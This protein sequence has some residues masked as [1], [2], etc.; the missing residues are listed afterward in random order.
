M[1]DYALTRP[2]VDAKRIALM[3][4]SFG[5]Y[6]APR[7][8]AYEHRL[9]ACIADG[10]VYSFLDAIAP[11]GMTA[12]DVISLAQAKPDD[13]SADVW[14]AAEASVS[15]RW[16]VENGMF[17]FGAAS[18]A[19]WYLKVAQYTMEGQAGKIE[20]PTLIVDSEHETSF[21]GQAKKLYD[22]LTSPKEWMLFTAEEGAEEHCQ[23]GALFRAHERIF[24][25]LATTLAV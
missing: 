14:K 5:G 9:A 12:E 24:D 20:C 18:P 13:F 19:E 11:Q 7:A 4:I 8:A 3:G 15:V 21:P 6:M 16:G 10:G 17:T 23:A 22:A 1:V 2:E 25:W